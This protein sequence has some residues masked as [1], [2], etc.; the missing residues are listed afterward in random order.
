MWRQVGVLTLSGVAIVVLLMLTAQCGSLVIDGRKETRAKAHIECRAMCG[1]HLVE[2]Q[3]D[4]SGELAA[5]R[6]DVVI[7]DDV[8][9]E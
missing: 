3:F 8:E 4:G 6:C 2:V 7:P 9:V 5:C 1:G